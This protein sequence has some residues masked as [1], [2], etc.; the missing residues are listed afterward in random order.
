MRDCLP[1]TLRHR[2]ARS[3]LLGAQLNSG[4]AAR[5]ADSPLLFAALENETVGTWLRDFLAPLRSTP[6]GGKKLLNTLRAYLDAECNSSSAAA[7]L[8]VRRQTVGSRLRSA[9][10][11][12]DCPIREC[13]AELD[14][15][16]KLHYLSPDEHYF[17][18]SNAD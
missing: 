10:D 17:R 8:K 3:A 1:R 12:L 6:D 13:L 14:V 2:E 9:E 7:A 18:P 5:Y 15:A 16:L 4:G 11:L